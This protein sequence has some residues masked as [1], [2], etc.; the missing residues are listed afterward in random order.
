MDDE[1]A[2]LGVEEE[3]T[4]ED[5]PDEPELVDST[6]LMASAEQS[7][8]K[9]ATVTAGGVVSTFSTAEQRRERQQRT[10][11]GSFVEQ[12]EN[13]QAAASRDVE[14][15][16]FRVDKA[17]ERLQVREADVQQAFLAMKREEELAEIDKRKHRVLRGGMSD[18][19]RFCLGLVQR[20]ES[21]RR[22][23]DVAEPEF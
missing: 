16:R 10:E 2:A 12:C 18:V 6:A 11:A 19:G 14:T 9:V 7:F 17:E 15:A 20:A 3:S 13:E 23:E 21:R 4:F 8:G 22:G 5:E 1:A